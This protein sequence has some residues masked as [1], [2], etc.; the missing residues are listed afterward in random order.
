M[1]APEIRF[2]RSGDVS[3]AYQVVGEGPVDVLFSPFLGNRATEWEVEPFPRFYAQLAS[4][5]RLILF[6]K[7]GVGLSDRPARLPDLEAR[8]DDIRAVLD[9]VGSERAV[10]VAPT[11]TGPVGMVFAATYPERTA[12]LVLFNC[13]ARYVRAADYPYGP[14]REAADTMLRGIRAAYEDGSFHRSIAEEL[15][16]DGDEDWLDR[17]R[18]YGLT[19]ASPSAFVAYQRLLFETDVRDVLPAIR[20][21]TLVLY[22][23]GK[24]VAAAS[25]GPEGRDRVLDVAARIPGAEVRELLGKGNSIWANETSA[26]EIRRFVQ[27]L[28]TAPEP[29]TVLATV[30]FTDLVNSTKRAAEVGDRAWGDVMAQHHALVRRE[31][32]HFR[33][34][35]QDTAGDGFFATFDGPARAIRC[36]TAVVEGLQGLG[37][38]VRAGVHTGECELLDRKVAGI[39]VAIGARVASQAQPGEVL[40]SQTVKDLVAG[41]GLEFEERGE[42]ELKGVPGTWR[43][44][45]VV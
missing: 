36:A 25:L 26:S 14:T 17:M 32:A 45:S 22:R 21:P 13:A 23:E 7:R 10:L 2:A 6:D 34:T 29:E 42:H 43:L 15:G 9:A 44:H 5:S 41:S 18:L 4:F 19:S 16:Y 11:T 20:V 27:T 12:G 40:V 39:A 31:L 38:E 37:L 3:I 24:G 8:M 1:K 28:K 35:E 30:L 33:G